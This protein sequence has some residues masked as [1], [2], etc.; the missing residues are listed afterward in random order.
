MFHEKEGGGKGVLVKTRRGKIFCNIKRGRG[1]GLDS[2][3]KQNIN[4]EEGSYKSGI[5][6]Q[7]FMT[8]EE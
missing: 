1:W 5:F 2:P 3:L 6:A 4:C 7:I 8:R